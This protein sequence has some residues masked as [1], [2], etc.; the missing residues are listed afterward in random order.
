MSIKRVEINNFKS[1][2]NIKLDI[3]SLNCLIGENGAGKTNVLNALEYYY[4]NIIEVNISNSN[5]DD[6]NIYNDKLEISITYDLS[7][8]KK[9]L[10]SQNTSVFKQK[11]DLYILKN[12]VNNNITLKMIQNKSGSIIWNYPYEVRSLIQYLHPFYFID[13]R[14]INLT[15]WN[16]LWRIIGDIGDASGLDHRDLDYSDFLTDDKNK[17]FSR[18]I[19]ELSQEFKNSNI[20][21]S[22]SGGKSKIISLYQMQLGG[23]DFN[24]KDESL[25][26][27]SDGTNSG[28]YIKLMSFLVSQVQKLK[29]KDPIMIIDEPEIGLHPKLTDELM[30][31]IIY[32]SKKVQFLMATHSP[33]IIKNLIVESG[34]IY[35]FHFKNNYSKVNKMTALE[36]NKMK[37]I[38]S[39][40]EA[41]LYF[42]RGILFVEG[43][44]ELELF[45]NKYLKRLFPV[46]NDIEIVSLN[47]NDII[48]E[49]INPSKRKLE[50]PF[51]ILVDSDKIFEFKNSRLDFKSLSYSPFENKEI[52]RREKLYYKEKRLKLEQM[53]LEVKEIVRKTEFKFDKLLKVNL[54][55][56]FDDLMSRIK[57]YSLEYSLYPV[58]TTIEG[59]IVNITS[60]HTFIDWYKSKFDIS[61]EIFE[62]LIK[63]FNDAEM[64]TILRILV[65][66]K[67]DDLSKFV[68][69]NRRKINQIYETFLENINYK[70]INK[71]SGWVTEFIYFV[72]EKEHEYLN[73]KQFKDIFPELYDIIYNVEKFMSK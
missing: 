62:N 40:K 61:D 3:Q 7:R 69:E 38:V 14:N 17:K 66:G 39:E 13:S 5:F 9:I 43:P 64:S 48:L 52:D 2:N 25:N 36:D 56:N 63:E 70:K 22:K 59:S 1:L 4:E 11:I 10:S 8:I 57:E 32:L 26:Y 42:A 58:I 19:N 51:L 29:L 72:F 46:L 35:R 71:T 49:I 20:Q 41:S 44:T 18:S 12:L 60:Y 15:N 55:K 50:I 67:C 65:N 27:F 28:N 45:N 31:K 30:E 21:I 53:K 34:N 54:E 33:R 37:N 24:Y 16:D 23:R 47:S 68:I 73:R 6:K